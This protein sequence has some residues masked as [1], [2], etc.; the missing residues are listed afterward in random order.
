MDKR[1]LNRIIVGWI[2]LLIIVALF[3]RVTVAAPS[4]GQTAADFLRIGLGA[5][6]AGMGGA[7]TAVSTGAQAAYWNPAG[8]WSESSGEALL[9]HFAWYQD[10]TVEQGALAHTI[11]DRSSLAASIGF[12]NYGAIDGRDANGASTG[13]I[14]AYDWFGAVSYSYWVTPVL[15][16]GV[17]GKF[18]NQKLDD[19]G[20]ST[21]AADVGALYHF[22][23]VTVGAVLANVGPD[24]SFEG[25]SEHLPSSARL[26]AAV[27]LF[28]REVLTSVEIEKQ[29]HGGVVFRHGL[30]YGYHDQYFLRA[31]YNYYPG[32]EERAVSTGLSFGAGVKFNRVGVDYAYTVREHYASDDLHRFSLVLKFGE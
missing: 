7:Y 6:S 22:D 17:T 4:G 3:G 29:F 20:A 16:L 11:N 1:T 8:L 30:E 23:R 2:L 28:D 31:G 27:E 14:S 18:V 21:F 25:V 12:L 24:M 13:D 19:V 5:R 10:V 15:S 9:S 26:G 32:Q